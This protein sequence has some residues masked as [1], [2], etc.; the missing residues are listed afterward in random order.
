MIIG[1]SI[2]EEAHGSKPKPIQDGIWVFAITR[3]PGETTP[4]QTTTTYR[5]AV[6]AVKAEAKTIGGVSKVTVR[7]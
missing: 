3:R 5:E 1:T 7:A 2:Y 6:K 4:F